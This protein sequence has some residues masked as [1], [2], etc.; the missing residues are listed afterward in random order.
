MTLVGGTALPFEAG[1]LE[2]LQ[3]I[4][5]NRPRPV[6]EIRRDI[7]QVISAI[8]EKLLSKQQESRYNS[9]AGLQADLV[10]CQKRLSAAVCSVSD[11][12]IE[13][14]LSALHLFIV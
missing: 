11:E 9:A 7:P 4:S 10:E 5:Q 8:V 3:I 1:P 14:I 2:L 13:V 12:E 6:Q